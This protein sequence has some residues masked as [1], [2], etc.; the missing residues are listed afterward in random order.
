MISGINVVIC[1]TG[2]KLFSE[3]HDT[4]AEQCTK[5]DEFRS[6]YVT[7]RDEWQEIVGHD[8][9]VRPGKRN[10]YGWH[11]WKVSRAWQK[12]LVR[13]LSRHLA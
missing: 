12:M 8:E 1:N 10:F 3:K 4:I 7:V 6:R 5:C 13:T 11:C 2:T 9:I